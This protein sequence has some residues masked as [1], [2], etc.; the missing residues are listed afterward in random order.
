MKQSPESPENREKSAKISY[1]KVLQFSELPCKIDM[2]A[3]WAYF[4]LRTW[5]E[6]EVAG[7]AIRVISVTPDTRIAGWGSR[8]I[9]AVPNNKEAQP[10][11]CASL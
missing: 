2:F 6:R 9:R 5:D 11:G 1:K 7:S 4:A 3:S 10:R 8:P